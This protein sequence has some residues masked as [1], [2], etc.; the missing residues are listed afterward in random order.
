[1]VCWPLANGHSVTQSVNLHSRHGGRSDVTAH[2]THES[3]PPSVTRRIMTS[4]LVLFTEEP[5]EP[6]VFTTF[7]LDTH[8]QLNMSRELEAQAL[9]KGRWCPGLRTAPTLP[10]EKRVTEKKGGQVPSHFSSLLQR[11]QRGGDSLSRR[12]CCSDL[13]SN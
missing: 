9:R 13:K 12:V 7:C 1:M 2:G 11:I 3:A 10:W 6:Y 8:K 5:Q 4:R